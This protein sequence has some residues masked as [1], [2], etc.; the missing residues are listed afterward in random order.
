MICRARL[1]PNQKKI[2]KKNLKNKQFLTNAGCK[3][4]LTH[5]HQQLQSI[6]LGHQTLY[7]QIFSAKDFYYWITTF[8]WYWWLKTFNIKNYEWCIIFVTN[9]FKPFNYCLWDIWL[10][11]IWSEFLFLNILLEQYFHSISFLLGKRI[12]SIS[13]PDDCK[14]HE[15]QG[16]LLELFCCLIRPFVIFI[17][18]ALPIEHFREMTTIKRIP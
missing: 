5:K 1:S 15:T 14:K 9:V 11:C 4:Q 7:Y 8:G 16:N 12:W 13:T 2:H 17:Y 18:F 6:P 10:T 3:H